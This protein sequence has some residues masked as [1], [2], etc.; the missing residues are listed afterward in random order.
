MNKWQKQSSEKLYKQAK[1]HCRTMFAYGKSREDVAAFLKDSIYP[2]SA[3]QKL[4]E[5]LQALEKEKLQSN[6]KIPTI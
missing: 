3:V 4:L 5:E 6:V 2:E 1:L